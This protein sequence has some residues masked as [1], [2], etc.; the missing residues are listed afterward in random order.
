MAAKLKSILLLLFAIGTSAPA[1]ADESISG[2][3]SSVARTKG[4]L[5]RQWQFNADGNAT[6]TFGAV[7]DFHYEVQGDKLRKRLA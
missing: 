4:G 3:W 7:V 1:C 6:A 2:L 5:G